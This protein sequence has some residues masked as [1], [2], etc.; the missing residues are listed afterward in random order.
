MAG[1][2]LPS[3]VLVNPGV[4]KPSVMVEGLSLVGSPGMVGADHDGHI[5]VGK[6]LHIFVRDQGRVIGRIFQVKQKLRF[7]HDRAVI[8][9]VDETVA[10]QA[11]EG[12]SIVMQLR[13][14]P[15]VFESDQLG[16]VRGGTA[17]LGLGHDLHCAK[18]RDPTKH[19]S[20]D[21]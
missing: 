20:D 12:L 5:F 17:G 19:R 15:G 6:H 1:H 8:V 10:N 16:L 7:V 11:L 2:A 18:K 21:I 13:L 3:V 9:G 4:G 14:V